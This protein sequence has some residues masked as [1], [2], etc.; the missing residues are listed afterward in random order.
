MSSINTCCVAYFGAQYGKLVVMQHVVSAT[1]YL[2]LASFA[3]CVLIMLHLHLGV[4]SWCVACAHSNW[5]N[6]ILASLIFS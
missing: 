1:H 6:F 5:A 3:V 2:I 4:S